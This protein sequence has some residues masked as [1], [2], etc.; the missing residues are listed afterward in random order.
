MPRDDTPPLQH[1]HP[2][3]RQVSNGSEPVN[4]L[5]AQYS[6][7]VVTRKP[8]LPE[9]AERRLTIEQQ[10]RDRFAAGLSDYSCLT[11]HRGRV[12]RPKQQAM[13]V[14]DDVFINVVVET[15]PREPGAPDDTEHVLRA[16]DR[17]LA[18]AGHR[19][20]P[21]QQPATPLLHRRNFIAATVPISTLRALAALDGVRYVHRS[22]TLSLRLPRPDRVPAAA[23]AA[24]EP[25]P[26]RVAVD[27][28]TQNGAGVLIGI[29]DVGGFDFS[30]PD[31]LDADGNTR[32]V[33]IWDQGGDFRPPPRAFGYGAELTRERLNAALQAARNGGPPATELER[34]SQQEPGSHA[35]HVASIAAGNQGLCP[36]A[37]IAGVLISVEPPGDDYAARRWTFSDA[38]RIV[39]AVEYLLAVAE[40]EGLALSINI[41]LGTNGGS[42]DGANGTCRWLDAFLA[43]PG[44][45]ISIAAGNAG[46]ERPTDEDRFGWIMGRIHTS[47]KIAAKGL[48][49]ELEW[50]VVGD[51]IAD[52]SENELEIWYGAQDRLTVSVQPPG[53]A[54]WYEVA[55]KQYIENR[56]LPDGTVLSVYNELYHPSNG[57]NYIGVYL[58]PFLDARAYTPI[59]AG[60]WKVRLHGDE[61]RDGS[62]HAWIER[63]DPT[64]LQRRR[65]LAAYRFPSFFAEATNVD[66]HSINSLACAHWVI[67]VA[68]ADTEQARVHISSS[69]GPTR[70][71]RNKP[72]VCAPGT[73]IV[74]ANGFVDDGGWVAMTGTSMA[75]PYVCG[76]IGLMLA[77]R[78]TLTAAQCQGILR[79][80]ARPLPSHDYAWRNDAGYGLIDPVAAIEEARAFDERRERRDPPAR[81][82]A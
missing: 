65:E 80:T 57:D 52:L 33:S 12:T 81:R 61:I 63:D 74:A 49:V 51:G 71:G 4:Q 41:S 62:F 23:A 7:C 69:Q 2:K 59:T 77:A 48:T 21:G 46:Q 6:Q 30:H 16:I 75:S 22:E 1:L 58:S 3:L 8:A 27:G 73:G 40:R 78:P 10:E 26:R 79:R 11:V 68:N 31:F 13:P 37:L 14:A 47:G 36:G 9:P 25:T 67:G 19:R 56:R 64:E 82:R 20:R 39:H 5:R 76:V 18:E 53:S 29:I 72:D 24:L 45:A 17:M 34:Q 28:Q 43:T 54:D 66:S 15:E 44:R 42:H 35:T 60:V 70:D 50:I 55:P 38:S 32:F